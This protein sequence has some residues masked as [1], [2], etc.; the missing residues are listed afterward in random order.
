MQS[1]LNKKGKSFKYP[2]AVNFIVL[3]FYTSLV[4]LSPQLIH[5]QKHRRMSLNS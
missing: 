5:L 4:M 2:S 1:L 3:P